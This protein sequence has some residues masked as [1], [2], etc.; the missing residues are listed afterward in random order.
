MRF[1]LPFLVLACSLTFVACTTNPNT[2]AVNTKGALTAATANP[3]VWRASLTAMEALPV[4]KADPVSGIITYDWGSFEGIN[5]DRIKATVYILDT[6]LRADVVKVVLF[7]ETKAP[8]GGWVAADT[9]PE[10]AEQLE[11]KILEL[12]RMYSLN[13]L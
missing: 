12:A 13:S 3:M 11:A 6:R 9:D 2:S 5:N 4:Q 1:R 8:D 7:R 10:T